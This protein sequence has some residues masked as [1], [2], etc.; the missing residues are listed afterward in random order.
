M[1]APDPVCQSARRTEPE[2]CTMNVA[3]HTQ[4]LS[5]ATTPPHFTLLLSATC[6][7]GLHTKSPGL[8]YVHTSPIPGAFLG[9]AADTA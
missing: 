9:V 8:L 1:P 4:T 3:R 6:C 7:C 5:R 2:T